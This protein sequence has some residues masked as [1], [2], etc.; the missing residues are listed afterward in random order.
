MKKTL[1]LILFIIFLVGFFV[2]KPK[3]QTSIMSS[4]SSQITNKSSSLPEEST[5]FNTYNPPKE[6]HFG[7]GIDLK[8]ELD[9]VNPQ[10]K[11][12]DFQDFK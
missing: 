7:A 2:L 6:Y 4:V 10:V 8:S 9:S 3:L 1:V 12:E 11:E 5:P